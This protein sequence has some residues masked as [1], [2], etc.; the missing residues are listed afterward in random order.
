MSELR[1]TQLPR[2]VQH[3]AY[4]KGLE[5]VRIVF[6]PACRFGTPTFEGTRSSPEDIEGELESSD[7]RIADWFDLTLEQVAAA[8]AWLS[9]HPTCESCKGVGE[10]RRDRRCKSC[11]GHGRVY[12]SE[13]HSEIDALPEKIEAVWAAA[14][15]SSQQAKEE[16]K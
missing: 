5:S 11:H 8:R 16:A 3:R 4:D 10:I 7:E 12:N 1:L 14:P 9:D 15:P 13:E 2:F 6:D